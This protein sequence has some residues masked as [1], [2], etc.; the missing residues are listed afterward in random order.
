MSAHKARKR[1]GQ[2][3]LVDRAI[4]ADCVNAID[5]KPGQHIVEI[6]PG[7]GALTAGLLTNVGR[8]EA[9][10][11]DRDIIARLKQK[12]PP[13]QLTLHA[14][15]ALEFDFNPLGA[16]LRIVGNLPYNISTPLLFH[17]KTFSAII[18]DM[19]FMLQKEVVERMVAQPGG[20]DYGR[21]S[22]M[23][24]CD[25]AIDYLFTVPASAFD[26]APQV[27]SSFVRLKPLTEPLVGRAHSDRYAAVVAAAFNQRRKTLRNAM[28]AW[29][30]AGDFEQLG[31]DPRA[32][33]EHLSVHDYAG[34]ARYL[35]DKP[36]NGETS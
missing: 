34:I 15:D 31:I 26:P 8:I 13:E 36:S 7:L 29:L 5:P 19:H 16:N 32:R 1:F 22:V 10:E 11:I 9:V 4:L 14:A 33:A 27:E 23:L 2:N 35:R 24:Q 28:A 6:G 12:F 21:L 25:F 3:F 30:T 20:R 17:L 18:C